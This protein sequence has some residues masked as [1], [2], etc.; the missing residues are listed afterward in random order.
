MA[1]LLGALL[2]AHA[3]SAGDVEDPSPR[4][5]FALVEL[6]TSEGCSSCPPADK[7]AADIA[8]DAASKGTPVYVVAFHVDYWD[9]LGW[10]DRFASPEYSARQRAYAKWFGT[11]QVYTP[12][13]VVNGTAEFVGSDAD[14][15]RREIRKALAN[16]DR[17]GGSP[18][19]KISVDPKVRANLRY[20]VSYEVTGLDA[21]ARR[22]AVL[23]LG[24]V[25]NALSS[26][27]TR[28]ENAGKTLHHDGVVRWFT[29]VPIGEKG[30]GHT[31]IHVPGDADPVRTSVVAWVQAGEAGEVLGATRTALVKADEP[32]S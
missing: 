32:G 4:T 18:T 12:Q 31:M 3:A 19:L 13:M 14:R 25:E 21:G 28:G 20:A 17:N 27:V 5:G 11:R 24:V 29:S 7:V 23:H 15:A 9:Y 1:A 16:D 26:N 10:K 30:K 8:R 22:D 6:F 2:G